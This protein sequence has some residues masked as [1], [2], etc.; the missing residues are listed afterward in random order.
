MTIKAI[1][2]LKGCASHEEIMEVL[3]AVAEDFGDV[4]DDVNF[5]EI[6]PL[7]EGSND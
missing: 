3:A 7:K 1:E 5:M 6:K 2:L 4:M